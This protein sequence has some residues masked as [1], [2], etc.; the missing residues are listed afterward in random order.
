[1]SYRPSTESE[2]TWTDRLHAAEFDGEDGPHPDYAVSWQC[3][4]CERHSYAEYGDLGPVMLDDESWCRPCAVALLPDCN[5]AERAEVL[6]ALG[7]AA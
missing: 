4:G 7:G 6:D 1:M 3:T 5:A 2:T